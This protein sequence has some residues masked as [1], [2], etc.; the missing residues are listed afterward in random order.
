VARR[1]FISVAA[2]WFLLAVVVG[3]VRSYGSPWQRTVGRYLFYLQPGSL[4]AGELS[5]RAY[6]FDRMYAVPFW[7]LA[8]AGLATAIA[9]LRTVPRR[10]AG[11]AGRCA[12]CGYDLRATPDRCPECGKTPV[13]RGF[14]TE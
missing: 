2:A 4:C 12:G 13:G 14:P 3:W 5:S 6:G 8:A 11:P 10:T 7:C 1:A 9:L